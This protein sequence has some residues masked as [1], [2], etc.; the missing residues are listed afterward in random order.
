MRAR[1]LLLAVTAVAVL[2]GAWALL[3]PLGEGSDEQLYVSEHPVAT[4]ETAR[5]VTVSV[6]MPLP[7]AHERRL[8]AMLEEGT[9]PQG[10]MT[11]EVLTDTDCAP[12]EQMI[13]RCRNVMRL[14]DGR[15][16]VLRHPHD[17]STV[18]CLAPGEQ[19]LLVPASA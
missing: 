15:R 2:G 9:M 8:S 14:P 7:S 16:I 4:P 13:S 5:T 18:P 10:P 1:R 3:G 11:A 6:T 17:M 12:D 19:V